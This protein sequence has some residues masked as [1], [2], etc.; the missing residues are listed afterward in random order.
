MSTELSVQ[1]TRREILTWL[2]NEWDPD[3]TVAAWWQRLTDAGLSSPS[4]PTRL[5][6]RGWPH[7]LTELFIAEVA[8]RGVL[9]P[10]L[11]IGRSLV[12]PTLETYGTS[13]Q[14]RRFV[15][16]ILNGSEAWCQLFSEPTAGSDLAGLQTTAI[17]D[18]DGWIV[19]GE[20]TWTSHGVDADWGILL[21]RTDPDAPKQAGITFFL[22]DMRQPGVEARPLRQMTGDWEFA[23][24]SISE[25]RVDDDLVVGEVH[26]GWPIAKAALVKERSGY[27]TNSG[28]PPTVQPGALAGNLGKPAGEAAIRDET[29][30]VYIMS[31][32]EVARLAELA[33]QLDRAEDPLVV[34][35]LAKLYSLTTVARLNDWREAFPGAPNVAKLLYADAFR[36]GCRVGLLIIGAHGM[37]SGPDSFTGGW[38]QRLTVFS[39]GPSIYGGTDQIQR[40]VLAERVLGMP[41][42][43]VE[44]NGISTSRGALT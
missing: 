22:F 5:G 11:G 41:K 4:T 36:T 17:R 30:Q 33:R 10:P 29:A 27:R 24:V 7:E 20:K 18:G 3:L 19:N 34:D 15:P 35:G 43:P 42:E 32:D 13:E 2:D 31:A 23:T 9:G 44:Q 28:G 37:T 38:L 16:N 40:N 14:I 26:G 39:P 1:E 25:A 8:D 6:G 21:A 12:L